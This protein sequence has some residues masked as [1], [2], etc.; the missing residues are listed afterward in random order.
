MQYSAAYMQRDFFERVESAIS[1]ERLSVYAT[2]G[3]DEQTALARYLLNMALSQGLY[4]PLQLCEVA[5]R[6]AIHSYL[7]KIFRREDWFDEPSFRLTE[8]GAAE[9][10]KAK[11]KLARAQKPITPGRVVAELQFGF[12]TSMFEAHYERTPF[13]PSGMKRVFPYLPKSLHNRKDRKNDLERI[14]NLRNRVFHHERLLHWRDLDEQHE[15]LLRLIGWL[16]R[17]LHELALRLDRF[18]VIRQA[19]LGPW[20]SMLEQRD[21]PH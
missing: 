21:E 11:E 8:W 13:L 4:V 18:T 1:S 10:R 12:W 15:L 20:R 16:N 6:N 17:T 2:D 5:L 19:G 9:V 3:V 7:V 14:R